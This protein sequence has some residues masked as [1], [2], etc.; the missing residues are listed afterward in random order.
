MLEAG[1]EGSPSELLV[2]LELD[3]NRT[4]FEGQSVAYDFAFVEKDDRTLFVMPSG[5]SHE[6]AIVD[7]TDNFKTRYVTFSDIEFDRGSAPHGRYR[8]VE[9]A[10][11]TDYVWTDDS[12]NDELYVID[13]I[14]GRLVNTIPSVESR[15]LL[16]VQN[17]ER[18]RIQNELMEAMAANDD[19][20]NNNNTNSDALAIAAIVM[21][22][23]ALIV[24][25]LNIAR[26][27]SGGDKAAS[28]SEAALPL[29]IDGNNDEA[30]PSLASVN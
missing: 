17:Y 18:L 2:D 12:G 10:V 21:G 3:F 20:N 28:R 16:S 14:E 26:G 29:Q 25:F 22:S 5:T 9:W 27:A 23:L 24:G 13:V 6:V 7:F 8:R 1:A 11:G 19:D 30:E 4:G 15:A